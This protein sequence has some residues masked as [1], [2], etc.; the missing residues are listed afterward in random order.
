MVYLL[1]LLM[2]VGHFSLS[3]FV[4]NRA[5]ATALPYWLIKVIDGLWYVAVVGAPF[6]VFAYLT[7]GTPDWLS[8]QV[9][10]QYLL[11]SYVAVCWFAAVATLPVWLRYF[12]DSGTTNRLLA[13]DCRQI[14]LIERIGYRPVGSFFTRILS[15]LPT[16]Q[17]FDLS[18]CEKS[19]QLPRLHAKLDG[20]TITH[21]SDLHF[22]GRVTREF[23]EVVVDEAN[24]LDSDMIAIT[25]DIIDKREC[26]PWLDEILGRLRARHGVYFVLGNH[27]LRVHDEV[28]LRSQLTRLGFT[29]L[30]GRWQALTIN[31]RPIIL[32]GNEL[33]WFVPAADM[34]SCPAHNRDGRP[35][36]IALSHS[37]DQID[38]CR[39]NDCDLMLAGHTHGGQIRLPVIGPIFSPSRYG[40]KYS[41]GTF[42]AD[43]TLMHVSRGLSGTRPLRFNCTPELTKLT[44]RV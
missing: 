8:S 42:F 35:L 31:Q 36:R 38:W 13:N 25:G 18:I 16:N 20:I 28:G 26:L 32:A 27:D 5:H 19:L 12:T 6:L 17:V 7:W 2:L 21:L 44:L 39:N 9:L 37:P 1:A 14:D 4:I 43:P 40:V 29:D 10:L 33:P 15:Q 3:I 22:T 41:A 11:F 24:R 23:Y 30:G 34:Q